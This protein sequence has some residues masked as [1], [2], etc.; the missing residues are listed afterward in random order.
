MEKF[1]TLNEQELMET[2][3]GGVCLAVTIV[4]VVASCV[5]GCVE[6]CSDEFQ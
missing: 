2:N 4:V 5:I 1:K 6:G 3:G